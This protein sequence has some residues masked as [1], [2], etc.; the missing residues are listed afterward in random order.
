MQILL[1][2]GAGSIG[3]HV[4][5]G[6]LDLGHKVFIIDN[7]SKGNEN[8]IPK[9]AEFLKCNIN[10]QTTIESLLKK[11]KFDALMHFAGYIE[12]EE[13][14][15]Y[16]EK[17]FENNTDNSIKLFEVCIRNNL[18]NILFSSTAAAYGN[19]S[20]NF[21]I[22][23]SAELKPINP[24]G[25][26][27]VK[28]ENYLIDGINEKINYIILRYFN[29]AGADPHMRSGLISKN[30]THLIKI[31]SEAATGKREKV[32]IFGDDYDTLDGTAIRDYIHITDL[33]EIHIKALNYM[34]IN[35]K[36]EVFNCGYGKG[37]SVKKVLD[38][39]NKICGNKI[40]IKIGPRRDGDASILVSDIT[41]LQEILDWKPSYNKLD[42]II[43]S[44]IEWENKIKNDK[45]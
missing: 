10:D 9:N 37:Y 8:L 2:G 11:K 35:K 16:P 22:K 17:Y 36:S 15:K 7:L 28:T 13:S 42:Y 5:L 41:K 1:T 40:N 38:E 29:V 43:K 45:F 6:L 3:S 4:A 20:S 12:V 34:I 31:A 19:P 24:Y 27:K 32:I 44:S 23:E 14:V 18:S 33:A 30:A 21:P 25:E 39:A 26:S